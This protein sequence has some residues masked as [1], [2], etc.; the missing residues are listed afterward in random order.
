LLKWRK[1]N[2]L[3]ALFIYFLI[4]VFLFSINASALAPSPAERQEKVA[5]FLSSVLGLDLNKYTIVPP[6]SRS[7][8]PLSPSDQAAKEAPQ[9]IIDE[10]NPIGPE[11]KVSDLNLTSSSGN[12]KIRSV[13]IYDRIEMVEI[14]SHYTV[15]CQ[16]NYSYSGPSPTDTLNQ[17]K[18]ILERYQAFVSKEYSADNSYLGPMQNILT[19]TID[20]LPKNQTTAYVDFLVMQN[21]NKT[22]LQWFGLQNGVSLGNSKRVDMMFVNESLVSFWDTWG[23]YQ[24]GGSNVIS[25]DQALK[26]ALAAA[27]NYKIKVGHEDGTIEILNVPDLSDT[28][29]IVNFDYARY[30]DKSF[31]SAGNA[32]RNSLTLYPLWSIQFYFKQAIGGVGGVQVCVWGDTGDVAHCSGFGYH[33]HFPES[34]SSVGQEG[35][36]AI[37]NFDIAII[38]VVGII[39]I[40]AML[41]SAVYLKRRRI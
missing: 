17:A 24:I 23:I 3:K 35:S 7:A 2:Y 15:N 8:T 31:L 25:S 11:F 34:S 16:V 19:S 22:Q 37:G 29:H 14:N 26:I 10:M 41:S 21:G 32:S 36:S 20:A 18:D 33:D 28:L 1:L 9:E 38:S 27:Q 40:T 39:A 6:S 12:L 13:F 4:T 30:A 5:N